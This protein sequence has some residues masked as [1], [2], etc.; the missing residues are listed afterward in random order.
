MHESLVFTSL[1]ILVAESHPCLRSL[2]SSSQVN[3]YF[4]ACISLQKA[5]QCIFFPFCYENIYIYVCLYVCVYSDTYAYAYVYIYVSHV[6]KM[7]IPYMYNV[8]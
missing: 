6:N 5:L 2:Q 7:Y 3:T 4:T 1:Q 8:Y